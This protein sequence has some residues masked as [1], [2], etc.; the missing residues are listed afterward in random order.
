MKRLRFLPLAF[1]L[2]VLLVSCN[3]DTT[4]EWELFYDFTLDDIK[5]TYSYSNVSGAF[6]GLTE[7]NY[8]HICD[9]AEISVSPYSVSASSIEFKVVC[10]KAVFN[11]SFIGR[12]ALNNDASLIDMSLPSTSSYPNYE[13]TAYVYK[14]EKGDVRLHGFA[15]H[16]YYEIV[17][18]DGVTIHKVT[19]IVNYYFD[20][21]KD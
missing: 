1:V 18:E 7:N 4:K 17:E 15:K 8:F 10:P 5:G 9:D 19:A 2:G 21:I 11:K 13:L 14:N 20:V 16:I 6:D 3:K 12:P